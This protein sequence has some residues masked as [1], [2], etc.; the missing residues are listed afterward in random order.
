MEL[1]RR[2][3][4]VTASIFLIVAAFSMFILVVFCGDRITKA[5]VY[6]IQDGMS[7]QQVSK[8]LGPPTELMYKTNFPGALDHHKWQGKA[9][10]AAVAF[11]NDCVIGKNVFPSS[12]IRYFDAALPVQHRRRSPFGS[13]NF[14]TLSPARAAFFH[15]VFFHQEEER[16]CQRV[17]ANSFVRPSQAAI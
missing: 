11:Q 4:L 12:D 14:D 3:V 9:G 15:C 10:V 6:R 17:W 1:S 7:L 5:N 2:R 8:I 13:L 16:S